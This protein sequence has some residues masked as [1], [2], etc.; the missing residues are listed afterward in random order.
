MKQFQ[1]GVTLISLLIGLLISMLCLIAVLSAYRTLV[2][3]SVDA[4]ISASHDTKLQTGLTTA[5]M[6]VQNAGFGLDGSNHVALQ[7]I[8]LN[9]H[10]TNAVLW[11]MRTGNKPVCQGLADIE[12]ADKK[13]RQLVL[14]ASS[15]N[16]SANGCVGSSSLNTMQWKV[17]TVLAHLEDVS[18]DHSN[19]VQISFSSTVGHCSPYGAVTE[20]DTAQ[21]PLILMNAKTSTQNHANL[22]N[23]T[24]PVCLVNILS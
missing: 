15:L 8:K 19:P 17:K 16:D 12:S 11:R 1:S 2:K 3:T 21:H 9:E 6:Y 4:R 18:S 24:V 7:S 22:D 23:L 13:K 20:K 14:L 5:Q 10:D